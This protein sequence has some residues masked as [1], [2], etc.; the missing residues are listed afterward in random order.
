MVGKLILCYENEYL[1]GWEEWFDKVGVEV[2]IWGGEMVVLL[3]YLCDEREDG[4]E[5]DGF[6]DMGVVY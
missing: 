4:E 6:G 5:G 1:C 3:D 2:Y